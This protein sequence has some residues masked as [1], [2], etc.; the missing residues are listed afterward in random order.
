MYAQI[1]LVIRRADRIVNL[2]EMKFSIGYVGHQVVA[3]LST[4]ESRLGCAVDLYVGDA[5]VVGIGVAHEVEA[6]QVAAFTGDGNADFGIA[7]V[8][9]RRSRRAR[10]QHY[11]YS[12]GK[13]K[14]L[15]SGATD[16]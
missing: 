5:D 8:E 9:L 13:V 4:V 1:D 14:T 12:A 10:A 6:S 3:A 16:L 2:C 11:F 15:S 7:G